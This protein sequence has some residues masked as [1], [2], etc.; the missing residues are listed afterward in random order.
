MD[1][2]LPAHGHGRLSAEVP[3]HGHRA[4]HHRKKTMRND[5]GAGSETSEQDKKCNYDFEKW[6][7]PW[8]RR[9]PFG[10]RFR[11]LEPRVCLLDTIHLILRTSFVLVKLLDTSVGNLRTVWFHFKKDIIAGLCAIEVSAC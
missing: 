7:S 9:P 5:E 11:G 8:P 2:C 6:A 4:T 3:D 1:A 10:D